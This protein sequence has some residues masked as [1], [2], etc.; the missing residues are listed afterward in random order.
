MPITETQGLAVVGLAHMKEELRIP[1]G[2]LEHD[3][4]IT[5]QIVSAVSY[6][7]RTGADLTDPALRAVVVGVVRALYDGDE[8]ITPSASFAALMRP[9][10]SY[11]RG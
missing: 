1:P 3:A 6:V 9:F 2:E 8:E 11:E 4:L 5:R 7:A 10:Q